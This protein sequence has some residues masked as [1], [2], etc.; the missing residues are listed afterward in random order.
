MI[1]DFPN[2]SFETCEFWCI[3]GL[4]AILCLLQRKNLTL[5]ESV[6]F[7][8][9]LRERG[10]GPESCLSICQPGGSCLQIE[11]LLKTTSENISY[12]K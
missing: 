3:V 10:L 8:V 12:Q 1:S 4:T 7:I 9:L 5:L 11:C 2:N 6:V